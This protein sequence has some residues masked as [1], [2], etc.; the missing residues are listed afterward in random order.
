MQYIGKNDWLSNS[1]Y[2]FTSTSIVGE[3][4][5][6]QFMMESNSEC[7]GWLMLLHSF[8]HLRVF[9]CL[10]NTVCV[11]PCIFQTNCRK[12]WNFCDSQE[13]RSHSI[14]NGFNQ[15]VVAFCRVVHL[16]WWSQIEMVNV[17][18]CKTT[19]KVV[20]KKKSWV[21]ALAVMDKQ[22]RC[23]GVQIENWAIVTEF[24]NRG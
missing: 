6:L 5:R 12:Y 10:P 13:T 17:M 23:D 8:G 20:G 2:N 19:Y 16:L 15:E 11:L 18:Y 7:C 9:I 24:E 3:S 22:L 21:S 1:I 14:D 4:A